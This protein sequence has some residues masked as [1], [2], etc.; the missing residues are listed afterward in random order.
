MFVVAVRRRKLRTPAKHSTMQLTMKPQEG[1]AGDRLGSY[2][3][4]A[5]G[6]GSLV[7]AADAAVVHLDVSSIAGVNGGLPSGQQMTASLAS[8]GS[9][10][11]G[12]LILSHRQSS[13]GSVFTG[14]FPTAGASMANAGST[15]TP[16]NFSGGT[17]IGS[18]SAFTAAKYDNLFATNSYVSPDFGADSF[19]GFKSG[20]GHY[21][22]LEVTWDSSNGNFEILGGAYEDV[23]G[24]AIQAGAVAAVPEPAGA[25]GTLGLLA[26]G[27]FFRRRKQAA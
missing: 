13:Y 3:A 26:G 5:A 7:T 25:L 20:D 10:L 2:L 16:T 8:L 23:A 18:D 14:I 6:I 27:T 11:D 1:S 17:P 24:V 15:N 21:G 4:A 12:D 9:D 19:I 22:W